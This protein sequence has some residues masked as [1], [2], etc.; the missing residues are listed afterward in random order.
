MPNLTYRYGDTNNV[1]YKPLTGNVA[2]GD[3]VAFDGGGTGNMAAVAHTDI[4][5]ATLGAVSV[6]GGIYSAT[7]LT[8]M[9][10]GA[11]CY[12]STSLNK[13]VTVAAGNLPFGKVIPNPDDVGNSRRFNK[14]RL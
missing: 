9:A 5:N 1:P 3:A 11:K 12:W 7:G 8:T 2:Y 10:V 14:K 6:G 13:M 4:A